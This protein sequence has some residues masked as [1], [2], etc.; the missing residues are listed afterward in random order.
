MPV[1]HWPTKI[2]N[3][4]QA[5]VLHILTFT[6]CGTYK[7]KSLTFLLFSSGF[8][9]ELDN[10]EL[11]LFQVDSDYAPLRNGASGSIS[12][13]KNL[14][15][16]SKNRLNRELSEINCCQTGK[17]EKILI[18]VDLDFQCMR[19][20]MSLRFVAVFVA[21]FLLFVFLL[22][23][24]LLV[25]HSLLV[26]YLPGDILDY[27]VEQALAVLARRCARIGAHTSYVV[28]RCQ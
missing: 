21:K 7:F 13:K 8:L 17:Y 1:R 20:S 16:I 3:L 11:L 14:L 5:A 26:L 12:L 28:D 23:N 10:A 9:I 2:R 27:G 4:L 19:T 22:S 25:S 15:S 24:F 18:T 6:I